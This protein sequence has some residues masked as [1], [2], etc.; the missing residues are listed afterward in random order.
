MF[1]LQPKKS[2]SVGYC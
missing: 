2:Q 1:Y